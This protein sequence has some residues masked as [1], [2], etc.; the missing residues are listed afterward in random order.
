[1]W[2]LGYFDEAMALFLAEGGLAYPD[3]LERRLRRATGT[4]RDRLAV[5]AAVAA[6]RPGWKW[7][8]PRRDGRRL[9][10]ASRS[11][12]SDAVVATGRTVYVVVA[13][14]GS[15]N[16]PSPRSCGRPRPRLAARVMDRPDAE[17]L[18]TPPRRSPPN[19]WRA[20]EGRRGPVERARAARIGR[21][22]AQPGGLDLVLALTDEVLRI[23]QPARAAAV[24][25]GLVDDNPTAAALGRFDDAGLAGRRPAG[26]PAARAGGAG[27]PGPGAGRDGGGD[28]LRRPAAPAAP[29]RPPP[30]QGHPPQRQRPRRGHPRRGGG[31]SAAAPGPRPAGPARRRLRLG[32]DLLDLLAARRAALR[33]TRS[34]ASPPASGASTTPPTPTT[35]PSSSTSTWRSTATSS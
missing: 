3:M 34:G 29:H 23:R 8:W 5:I 13:T 6:S 7:R 25:T 31:R 26:G 17:R 4:H 33:R 32:Q 10:W 16:A 9:R 1:M 22:L 28:P 11:A 18:W 27:G 12:R 24:L 2:Y 35:R 21:M 14:D 19:C 20:A 15:G 30:P